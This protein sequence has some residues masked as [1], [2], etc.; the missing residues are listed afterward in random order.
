VSQDP[1]I[2]EVRAI[3]DALA[4]EHDYDLDSIFRMLR[5]RERTS[6]NPHVTLPPKSPGQPANPEN[7]AQLGEPVDGA[8]RGT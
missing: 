2:D 7:A 4:R 1:L 5:E 3:R 8:A 6:G